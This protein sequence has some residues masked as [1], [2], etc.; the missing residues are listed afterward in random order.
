MALM[1]IS[2]VPLGT[3][4]KS[5]KQ[6]VAQIHKKLSELGIKAELTD[7]GTIIEGTTDR[8]FEVA[9]LLHEIPFEMGEH[10]VLTMIKIDDRR[11]KQIQ[12]G[13]KKHSVI[14]IIKPQS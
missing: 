2:I 8:L 3:C 12:L 13:E 7:M 5:F 10:R 1:D 4:T 11:D 6:Y 9:R 14:E